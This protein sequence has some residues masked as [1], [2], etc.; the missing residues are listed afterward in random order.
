MLVANGFAGLTPALPK[1][2]ASRVSPHRP[3][4][5]VALGTSAMLASPTL[6]TP[7][8]LNRPIPAA[9]KDIPA[10]VQLPSKAYRPASRT[11]AT[12]PKNGAKDAPNNPQWMPPLT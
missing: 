7:A 2:C 10:L 1:Y 9:A 12:D 6:A 8:L 5:T 3:S 11:E 4:T